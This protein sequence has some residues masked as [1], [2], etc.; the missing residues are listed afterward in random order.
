MG[1]CE[2]LFILLTEYYMGPPDSLVQQSSMPLMGQNGPI[3]QILYTCNGPTQGLVPPANRILYGPM[4][5][6]RVADVMLLI[7]Q[8]ELI[9]QILHSCSGPMRGLV[10]ATN[11]ILCGPTQWL[12]PPANRILCGPMQLSLTA[13]WHVLDGPMRANCSN[14]TCMQ[15]AHGRACQ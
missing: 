5:L 13:V 4:R 2:K 11:R 6:S 9:I 15:W 3:A 14:T 10:P 8:C 1:P 12:V 7:S